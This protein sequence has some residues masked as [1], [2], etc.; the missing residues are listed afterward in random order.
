MISINNKNEDSGQSLVEATYGLLAIAFVVLALVDLGIVLYGTYLND[1][2]CRIAARAAASGATF[3]ANARA[4]VALQ[5]SIME[6]YGDMIS[7]PQLSCPVEVKLTSQSMTRRDSESGALHEF[8]GPVTG[9]I[10]VKTQ[11]QIK[12]FAMD[13]LFKHYGPLIVQANQ[14]FPI[15]Y[16]I[17]NY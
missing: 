13:L 6:R 2:A 7:R 11:C 15:N 8:G 10:T 16:S 17:P 1:A 4:E 14:T 9:T 3:D 12:P 5:Q